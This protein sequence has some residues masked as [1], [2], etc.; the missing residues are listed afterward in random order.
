MLIIP[1]CLITL[2]KTVAPSPVNNFNSYPRNPKQDTF[3]RSKF[4]KRDNLL[5][6]VTVGHDARIS[7]IHSYAC[8]QTRTLLKI[9][10]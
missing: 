7:L 2:M 5:N 10:H 6:E 1:S 3:Y 4:Q 9:N 8:T